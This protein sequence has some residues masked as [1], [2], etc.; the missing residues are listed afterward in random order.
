MRSSCCLFSSR[1]FSSSLCTQVCDSRDCNNLQQGNSLPRVADY[2]TGV[3]YLLHTCLI[4]SM[5]YEF[6]TPLSPTVSPL[7]F[8]LPP[9]VSPP[10]FPAA[11]APPRLS[12]A[13]E[14]I[15]IAGNDSKHYAS[16]CGVWMKLLGSRT[17]FS[18]S[19][20]LFRSSICFLRSARCRARASMASERRAEVSVL[21]MT[22][23]W[24]S[25][26]DAACGCIDRYV[27]YSHTHMRLEVTVRPHA[28]E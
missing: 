26:V 15:F 22:Q 27:L 19:F 24:P 25:G 3:N 4:V 18:S 6:I 28:H 11:A 23:T 1:R 17:N 7:F 20:F 2:S 10:P 12:S 5:K 21:L 13:P 8:F 16:P 14:K 9:C